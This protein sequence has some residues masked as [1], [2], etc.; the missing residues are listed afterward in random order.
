MVRLARRVKE[1]LVSCDGVDCLP[2]LMKR[3][4]VQFHAAES[5]FVVVL[6]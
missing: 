2:S 5:F 6:N 1:A 4:S 3:D